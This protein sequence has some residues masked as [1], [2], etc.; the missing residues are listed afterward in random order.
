MMRHNG[1]G[2]LVL[3]RARPTAATDFSYVEMHRHMPSKLA[4]HRLVS[5]VRVTDTHSLSPYDLEVCTKFNSTLLA[6]SSLCGV[7]DTTSEN[8]AIHNPI[9]RLWFWR[10]AGWTWPLLGNSWLTP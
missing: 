10:M 2:I 5:V 8:G 6:I 7:T 3:S 4:V 1:G 9:Y